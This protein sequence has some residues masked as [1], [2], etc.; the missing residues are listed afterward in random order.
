MQ[1]EV[2]IISDVDIQV[3]SPEKKAE[4]LAT[5][6]DPAHANKKL[7]DETGVVCLCRTKSQVNWGPEWEPTKVEQNEDKRD[8]LSYCFAI[9]K[10]DPDEAARYE[11][12]LQTDQGYIGKL[13]DQ[14]FFSHFLRVYALMHQNILAFTSWWNHKG[15]M[16][17]IIT[18]IINLIF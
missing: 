12:E 18:S 17:P 14:D 15:P 6:V 1:A 7:L 9:V 3:T 10:P 5:F 4:F 13:S 2:A 16:D 11:E 8:S